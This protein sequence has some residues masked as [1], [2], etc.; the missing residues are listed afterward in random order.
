MQNMQGMFAML[1][2]LQIK[3]KDLI[4]YYSRLPRQPFTSLNGARL[5]C[6]TWELGQFVYRKLIQIVGAKPFPPH[7]LMLMA[8]AMVWLRPKIVV[9]WG[10]NIGVSARVFHEVNT[11]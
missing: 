1:Y 3:A 7:E 8:A 9:E 10:T 11:R 2:V 4:H 5:E 6:D